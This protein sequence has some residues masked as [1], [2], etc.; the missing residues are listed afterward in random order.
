MRRLSPLILMVFEGAKWLRLSDTGREIPMTQCSNPTLLS[1][2]ASDD[3]CWNPCI[4]WPGTRT[5]LSREPG[6]SN[7]F[8]FSVLTCQVPDAQSE[9]GE[10]RPPEACS[11]PPSEGRAG[12]VSADANTRG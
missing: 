4:E 11:F 1:N 10:H 5:W 12:D 7:P 3:R 6:T 9:P 8:V 2:S